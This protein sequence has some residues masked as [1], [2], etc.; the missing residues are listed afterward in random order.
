MLRVVEIA[1]ETKKSIICNFVPF[2]P[3]F[4]LFFYFARACGK[5]ITNTPTTMGFFL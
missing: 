3:F 5:V 1:L 2:M 4:L